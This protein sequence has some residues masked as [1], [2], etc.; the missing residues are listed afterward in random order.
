M[1]MMTYYTY[2]VCTL[3]TVITIRVHDGV[4][5]YLFFSLL[6]LPLSLS[7]KDWMSTHSC[8]VGSTETQLQNARA[9]LEK[10]VMSKLHKNVFMC[11]LEDKVR[12]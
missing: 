2:P 6:P 10:Y 5:V 3:C 11:E 7:M 12:T 9:G 4:C 1:M 8:W